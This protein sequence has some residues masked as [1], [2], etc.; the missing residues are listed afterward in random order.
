MSPDSAISGSAPRMSTL[1]RAAP[2][3][4]SRLAITARLPRRGT[5]LSATRAERSRSIRAVS[6]CS[7]FST[8][9]ARLFR[10]VIFWGSM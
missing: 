6:A 9:R 7:S 8:M 3:R 4:K 10:G 5:A 1:K 2:W